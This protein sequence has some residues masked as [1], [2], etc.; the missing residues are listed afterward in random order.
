MGTPLGSS[1]A[2]SDDNSDGDSDDGISELGVEIE[3]GEESVKGTSFSGP[4]PEPEG[5]VSPPPPDSDGTL[6]GNEE[7]IIAPHTIPLQRHGGAV[8]SE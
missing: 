5:I 8:D 2:P 3:I 7:A 6:L 4:L 1:S